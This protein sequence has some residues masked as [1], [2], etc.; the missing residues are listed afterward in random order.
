MQSERIF[1]PTGEKE[2]KKFFDK[3]TKDQK[4]S[5]EFYNEATE[6]NMGKFDEYTSNGKFYFIITPPG[7]SEPVLTRVGSDNKIY[8]YEPITSTPIKQK[9]VEQTPVEQTPVE[10]NPVEQNPVEQKPVEQSKGGKRNKKSKRSKGNIVSRLA[11][12]KGTL[13]SAPIRGLTPTGAFGTSRK[14]GPTAANKKQ[15]AHTR[16][17]H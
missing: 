12:A 11:S 8:Y 15:R 7:R 5:Y 17:K 3:L 10:Q 4:N 9:P 14:G 6:L 13:F 1:V 2:R 16:R